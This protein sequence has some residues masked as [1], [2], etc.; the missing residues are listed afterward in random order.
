MTQFHL[1]QV[2]LA[3][4]KAP[5]DST[6]LATFVAKLDEI[7]ALADASPG[8]VW[9]YIA[10]NMDPAYSEAGD[11]SVIFNM[12]VW[13]DV[14]ALHH[15]VYKTAHAQV[16]AQ[17]ATWFHDWQSRL[18]SSH[19]AHWWVPAGTLPTPAQGMARAAHLLAHGPTAHAFTFKKAFDA[20]GRALFDA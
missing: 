16:F 6:L 15:Y 2:N 3:H 10:N 7:N 4:L 8:F 9:R 18:A 20:Q 17:R 13:Q 12:S 14:A 11:A 5:M 19:M 1:A